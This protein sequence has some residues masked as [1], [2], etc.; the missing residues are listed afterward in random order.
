MQRREPRLVD[1]LS[2][3]LRTLSREV[4]AELEASGGL[5]LDQ[6]RALRL[7]DDVEGHTMGR[8]AERLRLPAA[9]TTRVVD[10]LIDRGLAF[11]GVAP[12]DRR[13]VVVLVS[14]A[15]A[16]LAERLESLVASVEDRALGRAGDPKTLHTLLARVSDVCASSR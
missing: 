4:A 13:Q 10:A 14:A 16:E 3:A 11:R 9:T 2:V 1:A 7:L 6:W 8:L 5:T 15:G 12:Q